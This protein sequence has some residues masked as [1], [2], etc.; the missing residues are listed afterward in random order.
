M[1]P[2]FPPS[3]IALRVDASDMLTISSDAGRYT[4]YAD[5]LDL[6]GRMQYCRMTGR[7]SSGTGENLNEGGGFP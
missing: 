4:Y 1:I 5:L 3:A 6:S 7:R 2:S